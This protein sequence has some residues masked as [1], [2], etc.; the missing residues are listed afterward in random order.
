MNKREDYLRAVELIAVGDVL[1]QPLESKHFPFH[2]YRAAYAF[3][4]D[5]ADESMKVFIDF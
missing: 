2:E 1:T 5:C 4:Q 3:I